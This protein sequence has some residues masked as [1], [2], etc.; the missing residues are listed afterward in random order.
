VSEITS[1]QPIGELEKAN[2]ILQKKLERAEKNLLHLEK[3]RQQAESL[4]KATI[5]ELKESQT[6]LEIRS[7][8]LEQA[9][10]GIQL[11]QTR[12][13]MVEK[14]SA[15]GVLVAGVAHEI[16]NPVSF[17]YGNL[18]HA[19]RYTQELLA[20]VVLYQK[21]YPQ[22]VPEINQFIQKIE[23]NFLVTDLPKVIHSMQIGAERIREIVL[24]L[25]T[26]SRVDEAEFKT[27]D[28]HEGIDSTLVI[29]EHRLKAQDHFPAIQVCKDY[30]E[31]PPVECYA[32]QL[33][34]V[35]A[36]ILINA[37]DALQ[38]VI[39]AKQSSGEQDSLAIGN[40]ES[41]AA[42]PMPTIW[43]KTLMDRENH[44]V[45]IRI[46]DNGT[47]IPESHQTRLFD[48]FFTTKP[49]GQ[50]TGLG[51]SIS[52]EIVTKR[53]KGELQC[54]SE[55]GTGTEFVITLPIDRSR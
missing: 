12:L 37:I 2:R 48:P 36:N 18:R 51:L 4:F 17:I 40:P 35:F 11:M 49:V 33:N 1:K 14:M 31:L 15:L 46:K 27:V 7:S 38:E 22:S 55:L 54:F 44:Q 9:L 24:S 34:Q 13:I 39:D 8:E 52:Y 42:D 29:L 45:V 20:L 19:S 53:H 32:G 21:H 3:S 30:G 25:R 50:G 47:G 5:A 26:F 41:E 28:I 6:T 23:L 10:M 43:I 16:N